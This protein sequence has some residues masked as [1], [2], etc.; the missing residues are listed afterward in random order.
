MS[1]KARF[2]PFDPYGKVDVYSRHLPHWR[3]D[4]C[5][6][7]VTF[8]QNDSLPRH[9]IMNWQ[10]E[11][12]IWLAANGVTG[13]LSG[14]DAQV[15]YRALPEDRRR[16]FE[17]SKAHRLHVELDKSSGSCLLKQVEVRNIIAEALHLVIQCKKK[18]LKF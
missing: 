13:P 4:G 15:A 9:V 5:T 10:E 16:A 8:R 2:K 12:N 3:Q 11:D 7:F 1:D 6:Y 14:P 18:L 17:R